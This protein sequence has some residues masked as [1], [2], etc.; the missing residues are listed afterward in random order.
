[1]STP[2]AKPHSFLAAELTHPSVG[3][4]RHA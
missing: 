3:F 1:M 4:P 2:D